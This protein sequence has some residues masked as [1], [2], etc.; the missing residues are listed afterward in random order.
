MT[1][2]LRATVVGVFVFALLIVTTGRAQQ[3]STG[4]ATAKAALTGLVRDVQGNGIPGATV[5]VKNT[6]TGVTTTV[7]TNGTGNWAVPDLDPGTYQV[8]ISLAN[9]KSVTYDKIMLGAGVSTNINTRLEVGPVSDTIKVTASTQLV[10]TSNANVTTTVSADVMSNLPQ[11]TKNALSFITFLP[12]TNSGSNRVQRSSTVMGL[13]PSALAVTLDGVNVMDQYLKDSTGSSFFVVTRPQ[14]DLIE[15]VTVSEAVAGGVQIIYRGPMR[16]GSQPP[17]TASYAPIIANPF[18]LVADQPLSTFAADVDTASYTNVRRFLT[19]GQLP[20]A[21]AVR[22]EELV[23]YFRFGYAAP[24]NGRPVSIT[25]ELSDCPWAPDH[26]LALIGLRAKPIDDRSVAGRNITLLLDVSGS[27]EPPERLPLIKTALR[28]WVDTLRDEDRVAI[29]VYAG[30]SGLALPAT[31][32][33]NRQ[34]IHD[35]IENL[36]AGGSTNGADGLRLAYQVASQNFIKGGINRVILA[37]DGDFNVGVTSHD[38][39]LS[40]IEQERRSGVF[41]SVL[42]VGTDNLK[43]DTMSMLA[44]KGNGHYAYLDSIQAARRVLVQ[45]GGA[46][47]E[48]VAKDV[49]LQIEFNPAQVGAYRLLG[50]EKRLLANRDFND[51]SKDG[52]E[53]GAGHTVTALYEIVPA[54]ADILKAFA[55][56]DARPEVDPLR[57]QPAPQP[58]PRA[59]T[60]SREWLTVKVRYKQPDGDR[61]DLIEQPLTPGGAAPHVSFA[62]AVAEFGMLLRDDRALTERWDSLVRRVRDLGGLASA[63]DR[64]SFAELVDTAASLKRLQPVRPGGR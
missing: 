63:A 33:R 19:K 36:H 30:A 32:G 29:V 15:E 24:T 34:V 55:D 11:V 8:L 31:S 27:M 4:Q 37:T 51:D 60:A 2:R 56:A 20:P 40:L 49:K 64:E 6:A 35:A 17:N 46:T 41:L 25:T 42:G 14:T 5:V 54:G 61:S 22:V 53:M 21:D 45:E 12:G 23:N 44:D 62:A 47:L 16:P 57:Y 50:Y 9:F 7:T 38:G 18:H 52:G 58:A 43:D 13:P 26:K 1:R 48:T 39:L 59:L 10:E 28:M 3:S